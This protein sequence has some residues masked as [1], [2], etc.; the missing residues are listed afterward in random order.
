MVSATEQ[1]FA[2][3]ALDDE[4]RGQRAQQNF[5]QFAQAEDG[6]LE[7]MLKGESGQTRFAVANEIV[8][9]ARESGVGPAEFTRL[10][11]SEPLMRHAAFQRMMY[12][13]G[14][15]R[16]MMKARDATLA[17]PL[18]PVQRPGASSAERAHADLRT[19]N[20]KLSTSGNIKDAVA[21]YQARKSSKR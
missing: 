17:R 16:L 11:N 14:K 6:R 4:R 15:Y 2:Q 19:L 7:A 1:M 10:F 13:A 8:A 21:L 9:A 12:D 18:P 20:A 5:L 3:Q